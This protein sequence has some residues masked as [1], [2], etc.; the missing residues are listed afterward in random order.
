MKKEIKL[1][2]I[3]SIIL[4]VIL[5]YFLFFKKNKIDRTPPWHPF[6]LNSHLNLKSIVEN[7]Y[8]F[9]SS[10][11]GQVQYTKQIADTIIQ[12]EVGIDCN[13]YK[14]HYDSSNLGIDIKEEDE[15]SL[16][17][18]EVILKKELKT[19]EEMISE[20]KYYPWKINEIKNCFQQIKWRVF[21]IDLGNKIDSLS[22]KKYIYNKGG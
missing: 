3:T 15:N 5:C 14:G 17:L 13:D 4:N 16:D 20:N 11:C 12:Y 18:E 2:I 6:K 1:I 8:K 19:M 22:L 10:P 9:D 7:G 21:T